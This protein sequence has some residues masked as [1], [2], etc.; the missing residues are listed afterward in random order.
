MV[1][2]SG[3]QY[4]LSMLEEGLNNI[5]MYRNFEN[6][7]TNS[8]SEALNPKQIQISQIQNP[9]Q[10]NSS[11]RAIIFHKEKSIPL[12]IRAG[13]TLTGCLKHLNLGF[14][15]C[16]YFRILKLGFIP[17][18]VERAGFIQANVGRILSDRREN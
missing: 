2:Q 12:L 13:C 11:A 10:N 16:L 4:Y 6:S 14:R 17:P 3:W 5:I 8:K 7:Y 9:K 18:F 1:L 15:N